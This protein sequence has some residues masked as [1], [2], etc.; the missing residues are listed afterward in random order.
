[1]RLQVLGQCSLGGLGYYDSAAKGSGRS[2]WR[3]DFLVALRPDW[4]L[5]RF[6]LQRYSEEPKDVRKL[7]DDICLVVLRL[8]NK[9]A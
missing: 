5:I 4:P 2:V 9:L 8:D 3:V 7:V 6:D 1:M